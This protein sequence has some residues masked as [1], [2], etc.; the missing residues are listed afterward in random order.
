MNLFFLRLIHQ[1]MS[2]FL[3]LKYKLLCLKFIC[4]V[5]LCFI[6]TTLDSLEKLRENRN[7]QEKAHTGMRIWLLRI[8]IGYASEDCILT[9]VHCTEA[10]MLEE[11]YF[12]PLIQIHQI[13]N[14]IYHN[15]YRFLYIFIQ[16]H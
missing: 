8:F 4:T 15:F 5:Q 7:C 10:V 3:T 16:F 6:K 13:L 12:K 11:L 14:K 2:H 9:F 1:K